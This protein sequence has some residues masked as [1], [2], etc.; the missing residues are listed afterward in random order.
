MPKP[1]NGGLILPEYKKRS[2]RSPVHRP[3]L[4]E[5]LVLPLQQH[6]G[7]PAKPVVGVGDEVAKGQCIAKA[8]GY[9]S[10]AVHAPTSG[11]VSALEERPVPHPSGLDGPCIVLESD[12]EDAW[13]DLPPPCAESSLTAFE[14]RQRVRDAGLVGLGGAAFPTA[15]KLN[16]GP[17]RTLELLLINGAECEPYIS[18]DD[19]WMREKAKEIIVGAM[20]I[21]RALD[22]PKC[23]VGVEDNKSEAIEALE[24]AIAATPRCG[25][26]VQ[27]VATVYPIGG[28][29]QLI[30]A[31]TGK[32]VPSDG[33]PAD[34]GIL[35]HNA[36]TVLVVYDALAEGRP[37][38]SRYV[39]VTGDAVAEPCNLEVLLGTPIRHLVECCGGYRSDARRLILGGPMMGMSVESDA[40]PVVKGT[41]CVL[42]ASDDA[43]P[44]EDRSFECIRCGD[45]TPVC[46]ARLLPQ[47]LYW[48]AR[49]RSFDTIQDVGLFDCIE[50]GCCA[51]VCPSQIPLVDYYRHAK[52]EIWAQERQ[53]ESA[54]AARRRYEFR[55]RR[56]ERAQAERAE[57]LARKRAA[58]QR[59]PT[60]RI[61]SGSAMER[62]LA[63][64]KARDSDGAGPD[65]SAQ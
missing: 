38:I 19:M 11:T 39:T 54:D 41:N 53:R 62:A 65:G 17:N 1:V 40:V 24:K 15:V 12:G 52:A 64:L 25:V 10:A 6:I 61:E 22:I 9:V 56:I 50:C 57:S 23:V 37:L 30:E 43:F 35:C 14:L 29:K 13:C 49:A 32:E 60:A 33:M 46:P 21:C 44:T 28:E 42:I 59:R 51:A 3:P 34:I 45:C 8:D 7:A 36:G 18:C 58:L 48:H 26:E 5:R 16:P 47:Q 63:R 2:T 27:Q 55:S 4:P 31:V 20:L